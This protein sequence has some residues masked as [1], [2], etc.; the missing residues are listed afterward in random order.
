[1][2]DGSMIYRPITWVHIAR[3][4]GVIDQISAEPAVFLVYPNMLRCRRCGTYW[5]ADSPL[6]TDIKDV[7][8]SNCYSD[9]VF[10]SSV[11][12]QLFEER[13]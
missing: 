8:C 1:M 9:Q 13:P 4:Q 3:A 2:R 12:I 5:V 6:N 10:M 11:K 7:T